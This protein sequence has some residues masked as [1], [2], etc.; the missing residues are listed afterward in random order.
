MISANF[1]GAEKSTVALSRY[2]MQLI[3]LSLVDESIRRRES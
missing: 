1:L 3:R 2:E